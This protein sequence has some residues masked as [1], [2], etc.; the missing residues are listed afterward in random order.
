MTLFSTSFTLPDNYGKYEYKTRF[1]TESIELL[2]NHT[3]IY[4][5]GEEFLDY[6]INGNYNI[7]GDSL[8]LDSNPQ[9]D[10]IIVRERYIKKFET[11]IFNV[12][13][14][15]GENIAY[16]LYITLNDGSKEVHKDNFGKLKFKSKPIK[17][18]HLFTTMGIKSP[19]YKLIG[20][21]TNSFEIQLET[22]RVFENENW[23]IDKVNG[24][25]KPKSPNGE[26]QNYTLEKI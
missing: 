19:E 4:K 10:K 22:S 3:F 9:K 18:F 24:K 14:K 26:I 16:H 6:T 13:N 15:R 12:T 5:R 8:V 25:I 2:E 7:V 11:K 23:F 1:I 17:S 20:T 21:N